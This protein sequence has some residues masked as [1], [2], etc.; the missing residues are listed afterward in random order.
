MKLAEEA[1]KRTLTDVEIYINMVVQDLLAIPSV[2]GIKTET[3]KFAG[4]EDTIY[5]RSI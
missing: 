2:R 4:A 5:N 3:E 1:K